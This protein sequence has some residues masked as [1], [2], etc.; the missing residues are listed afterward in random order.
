M[1]RHN[2]HRYTRRNEPNGAAVHNTGVPFLPLRTSNGD[3]LSYELRG[4]LVHRLNTRKQQDDD[5][6]LGCLG[7]TGTPHAT[8]SL[9]SRKTLGSVAKLLFQEFGSL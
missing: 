2:V 4:A 1:Q 6:S 8:S 9:F 7:H 5:H 3:A